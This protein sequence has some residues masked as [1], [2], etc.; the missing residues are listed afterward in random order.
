MPSW[1]LV[2]WRGQRTLEL[3]T[4]GLAANVNTSPYGMSHRRL[5]VTRSLNKPPLA[6]VHCR[7]PSSWQT[8]E[9]CPNSHSSFYAQAHRLFRGRVHVQSP[10][11]EHCPRPSSGAR[12][13]VHTWRKPGTDQ[14]GCRELGA[15]PYSLSALC[16][17]F[18][19]WKMRGW[20]TSVLLFFSSSEAG[21]VDRTW[22][23]GPSCCL[24]PTLPP[25]QVRMSKVLN[26]CTP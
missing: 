13:G 23:P 12:P 6:L 1:H 4:L 21:P 3:P 10:C 18:I 14:G 17:S 25:D 7:F 19:V 24:P 11:W 26:T 22:D 8:H 9:W 2:L 15:S 16:L 5:G 20:P